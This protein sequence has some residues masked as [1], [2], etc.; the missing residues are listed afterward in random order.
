MKVEGEKYIQ[1][2]DEN[3][4]GIYFFANIKCISMF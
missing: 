3:N 2:T 4:L 1:K